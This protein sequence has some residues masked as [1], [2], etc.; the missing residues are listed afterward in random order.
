[1]IK[2]ID[3]GNKDDPQKPGHTEWVN[4]AS[5][6]PNSQLIASA[7]NDNMIKIW[8]RDGNHQKTIKGH[9][10]KV[11]SARFLDDETLVSVGDDKAIKLWNLQGEELKT[12]LK[13]VS[14]RITNIKISPDRKILAAS[15]NHGIIQLW[16]LDQVTKASLS[17]E[18]LIEAALQWVQDYE[19]PF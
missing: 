13:G 18:K 15:T 11:W 6:S 3:K 1:L 10:Y 12:N 4:Q 8:D 17:F 9:R 5:F 16:N 14:N 2:S 19:K 7:S